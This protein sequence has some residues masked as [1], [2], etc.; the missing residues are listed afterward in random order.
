MN[1]GMCHRGARLLGESNA[2]PEWLWP[3]SSVARGRFAVMERPHAPGADNSGASC[4]YRNPR[5]DRKQAARRVSRQQPMLIPSTNNVGSSLDATTAPTPEAPRIDAAPPRLLND[6]VHY[7]RQRE[8]RAGIGVSNKDTGS[9]QFYGPSSHFCFIQRI[10]QRIK[11]RAHET[12]LTPQRSPV[13]EGV[14][15]WGLE[16]FMFSLS[17]D[18]DA[19]NCQSNACFPRELGEAFIKSYFELIHPQVPV[20]VYSEI[21]ELWDGM[22]Q[23]PSKRTPVKGEELLLMVL[24]IGARVSSFEGKQDVNVSEGWAAYFSKRADDATNLFENPSLRSTHF[25]L[26]KAMYA[27]QVMRPNDA[28]LCLGHAARNAMALGIN[29][30]QVVDGANLAMHRLRRTFWVI[31]A[32]ERACTIFTGRP[33]AFRDELIDVPYPE[34]LP[35]PGPIGDSGVSD[36]SPIVVRKCGYVRAMARVGKVADRIFVDIYSTKSI[37]NVADINKVRHAVIECDMELESITRNL[38]PYLH[39]FDPDL[40]VGD[41]WQEVQRIL[42]GCH[43][44]LLRVLMH[45]PALV[46]A[47]FFN[48]K[49]EAEERGAGA[50]HVHDSIEASIS[51]ARCIINLTHDAYSHRCSKIKFDGTLAAFLVSACVTL[52]YDVLDPGTSPEYARGTFSVV[53]RGIQCLDQLQHVG[54]INGKI[55]SLDIM[56]VAKD[57][58]QSSL[59][60]SQLNED[61]VDL[62]PWLQSGNNAGFPVQGNVSTAYME[63]QTMSEPQNFL[64]S[65]PAMPEVNYMSHWLEAGFDPEDIPNSL[66]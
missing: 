63:D 24:A 54:P 46:F 18:N 38:P 30:S 31:Y 45:R 14:G 51:S 9:F 1:R 65:L 21:M 2:S 19:T 23:P 59:A 8:L 20:L 55:L 61:L 47:T 37:S 43:Y 52:L 16:R 22:W 57:A 15:N 35:S 33:S 49:A 25:L 12:L 3:A 48:S 34:D 10:Y 26:L 40:P 4:T 41:G 29:R 56:K 36:P 7:K 39:F 28:Y 50:M 64:S 44:Y 62:F 11:R 53:E 17:A 42:L 13:P 32:Y 5:N 58:L 66:Y 60:D 6:P 27:F